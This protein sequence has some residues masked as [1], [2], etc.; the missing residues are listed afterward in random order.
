MHDAV[1]YQTARVS[2]TAPVKPTPTRWPVTTG[3]LRGRLQPVTFMRLLEPVENPDGPTLTADNIVSVQH[4]GPGVVVINAMQSGYQPLMIDD[5]TLHAKWI[6]LNAEVTTAELRAKLQ[7]IVFGRL[8]EDVA[9]N[10]DPTI[11]LPA[12][13][14]VALVFWG[15][16]MTAVT[17]V[18]TGQH[19]V[20]RTN[21]VHVDWHHGLVID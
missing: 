8:V 13:T 15:G 18:L 3:E 19:V 6:H 17:D 12:R 4:W 5:R 11:T 7:P 9:D 10:S 20:A 14:P 2:E 1:N 21:T 16:G